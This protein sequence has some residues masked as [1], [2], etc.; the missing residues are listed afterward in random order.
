[1]ESCEYCIV[2]NYQDWDEKLLS[3]EAIHS[4]KE[5]FTNYKYDILVEIK[6]HY[7]GNL[8]MTAVTVCKD[9]PLELGKLS[10]DKICIF[11]S[12]FV[13]GNEIC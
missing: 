11:W 7:V 10:D 8:S 5:H 12:L 1:M 13:V 4:L 6:A 2:E 9:K 3:R